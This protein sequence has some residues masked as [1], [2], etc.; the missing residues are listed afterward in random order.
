MSQKFYIMN[1]LS[2]SFLIYKIKVVCVWNTRL[3]IVVAAVRLVVFCCFVFL[4][5]IVFDFMCLDK[6]KNS[7]ISFCHILLCLI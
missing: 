7:D 5:E 1:V 6:T 4:S 2:V 3:E